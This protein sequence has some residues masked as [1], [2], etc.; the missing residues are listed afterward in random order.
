[1]AYV[2]QDGL[3][4]LTLADQGKDRR[5]GR[6][7]RA[8]Q[9]S[10]SFDVDMTEAVLAADVLTLAEVHEVVPV[11]AVVTACY[12]RIVEAAAGGTSLDVGLIPVDGSTANPTGI[13][14]LATAGMTA[15]AVLMGQGAVV[16]KPA[17]GTIVPTDSIL[18]VTRVGDFTAGRAIV[19]VE[20]FEQDGYTAPRIG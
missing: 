8:L 6:H 15:G 5:V 7:I 19:T 1:M 20:W 11:G 13:A 12:A 18:A 16:A 2:N 17:G 4:V 14:S 10:A 9:R 3:V